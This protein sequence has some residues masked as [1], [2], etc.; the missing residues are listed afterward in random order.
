MQYSNVTFFGGGSATWGKETRIDENLS[1]LTQETNF[2]G[3]FV[4][5]DGRKLTVGGFM[6]GTDKLNDEG[7]VVEAKGHAELVDEDGDKVW[8][9]L[10]SGCKSDGYFIEFTI[11]SG[12][13]KWKCASGKVG[14]ALVMTPG[15]SDYEK[16]GVYDLEGEINFAA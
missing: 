3:Q 4:F 2:A 15:G 7:V 8:C 9:D 13:G 11:R 5:N 14:G 16:H 6:T 10:F 12:V 1:V